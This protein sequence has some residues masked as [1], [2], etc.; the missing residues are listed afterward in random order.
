MDD[1]I[2][3]VADITQS[4]VVIPLVDRSHRAVEVE[5]NIATNGI[6]MGLPINSITFVDDHL[7]KALYNAIRSRSS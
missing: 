4:L 5:I 1:Y 3:G 2:N 6:V 7:E